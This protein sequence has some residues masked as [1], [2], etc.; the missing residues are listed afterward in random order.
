MGNVVGVYEVSAEIGGSCLIWVIQKLMRVED[1][2]S[3]YGE[4]KRRCLV[5]IDDDH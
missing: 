4:M 1:L 3:S 2:S 5:G